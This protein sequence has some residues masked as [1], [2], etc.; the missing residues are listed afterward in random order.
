MATKRPTLYKMVDILYDYH[1]EKASNLY[2]KGTSI[3]IEGTIKEIA[4]SAAIEHCDKVIATIK[5]NTKKTIYTGE[6]YS[7]EL[8]YWITVKK[9]LKGKQLG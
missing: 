6:R 1:H 4:C 5:P 7:D 3:M 8:V 2:P 9:M